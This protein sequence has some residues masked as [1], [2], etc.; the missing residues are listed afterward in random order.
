MKIVFDKIGHSPKPFHLEEEGVVF[1]G[2]LQ[3]IR[4]HIITLTGGMDGAVGVV[5]NRCGEPF[6]VA[7]VAPLRLKI[8]DQIAEDKDDLDIIEFLDGEIDLS[9]ILLSEIN[10]LKSEYHYCDQCDEDED[11]FEMEF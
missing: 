6:D 5:C 1:D 10:T 9:F 11:A 8:S 7:L 2:D 3:Q 4:K